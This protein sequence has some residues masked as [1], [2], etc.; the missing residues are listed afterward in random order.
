[1]LTPSTPTPTK[2]VENTPPKPSASPVAVKPPLDPRRGV[3]ATIGY[4]WQDADRRAM[5][6]FQDREGNLRPPGS[7]LALSS[8]MQANGNSGSISLEQDLFSYQAEGAQI[9]IRMYPQRFPGG[10]SESP[11]TT[12]NTVGGTPQDAVDDVLQFLRAQRQRTGKHFTRIVPGN[13]MNIEWANGSYYYNMLRWNS[14]DDPVK[15]EQINN[16]FLEMFSVWEQELAKPANALFRDVRLYFPALSQD[17]NPNYFGGLYFY[18]DNTPIENKLDK[19]RPAIERFANF[20]WHNYWRPGRV[21]E[22]RVAQHFP[23]WLKEA[24]INGKIGGAITEC[25]WNPQ[26]LQIAIPDEQRILEILRSF[27]PLNL[28]VPPHTY[29]QDDTVAGVKFEDELQRFIYEAS[30]ATGNPPAS[31]PAV[32]VWLAGSGGAFDE[33]VG[34]EKDGKVRRWFREFTRVGR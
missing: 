33:A 15:W 21:W 27:P 12:R 4:R 24:L 32:M 3:H 19:L 22:D 28:P 25:G 29:T 18:A 6:S 34:V 26:A 10:L 13:E 7:V 11:N 30:G 31:A 17:G 23:A 5:T 2:T 20:T 1:L 8:D 9:Y 16:Y 14:N